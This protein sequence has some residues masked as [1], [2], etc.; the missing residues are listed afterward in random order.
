[1]EDLLGDFS[2][3][4]IIASVIFGLIGMVIF[5][6]AR[7]ENNAELYFISIGLMVYPYF[8]TNDILVWV[9]GVGLVVAAFAVMA[10]K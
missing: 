8:V 9:V 5:K 2:A 7:K 10:K 1:M 6:A 3:N 4:V